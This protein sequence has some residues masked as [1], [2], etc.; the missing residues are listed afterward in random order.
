MEG[1]KREEGGPGMESEGKA[2][3]WTMRRHHEFL[4]EE[5]HGFPGF[6]HRGIPS[7]SGYNAPEQVHIT[8]GD[9]VG[10]A[11][12]VSWVTPSEPG[13][14]H[15]KYWKDSGDGSEPGHKK[16]YD[17]KY[18]YEIGDGDT[19]RRF[20]FTTPPPV[21]PDAAY[22]F[23][24][25]GDLGQT[26]DSNQTLEHYHSN[27]KGQAVLFV[28]DLSYADDH[29]LHDNNRWDTWGRFVEKSVAYQP[30]IW[31][32]G[33]HEIDFLPE[34]GESVPF[35]P[36]LHRY[37]TPYKASKS[38]FPLWYSIKRASAHI[39]VLSSYSAFGKY[40]PQYQWLEEEF[41]RVNRSETPWLIVLLHSPMYNS[42]DY[43]FMEGEA[44]R[45]M[46][47]PWFVQNKVDL[48]F[49]G[50]VHA[51]ERSHRFSNVA[52]RVSNGQ[53]TPAYDKSGPVY[54]TIGD[55]GNVE[56][57]A[58]RFTEPQ[59]S[60]SAYREASFGHAM[61]EIKNRTHAYYTWHRNQ[62]SE[63]VVGDTQWFYNR[64]WYPHEEP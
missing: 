10:R 45:V 46:F 61:L 20:S 19:A 33:N 14:G 42:Y 49:S 63:P 3:A 31:T 21:G 18:I 17:T 47:E 35:K 8:Q 55:G 60:Y 44:M 37:H 6:T 30:W 29:P 38:T 16:M 43:H 52:Y 24:I 28:G 57:I 9:Q 36:F 15:V 53:C 58:N 11:V 39:I 34:M 48:V 41:P 54:I 27:T 26:S 13:S 40:T 4:R 32:A 22:T 64:H 7:P 51:Y 5:V 56:G 59:P 50:H 12:I 1:A 2:A 25:I 62:D 23:G